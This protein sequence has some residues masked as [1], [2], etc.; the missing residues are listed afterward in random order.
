MLL[1]KFDSC[2]VICYG[3]Y[4]NN[5]YF[6]AGMEFYENVFIILL[7]NFAHTFMCE[8]NTSEDPDI[9]TAQGFPTESVQYR[10]P[11]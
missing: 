8:Q 6:N 9:G 5:E 11:G 7:E 10:L 2:D 4:V 3:I 1:V